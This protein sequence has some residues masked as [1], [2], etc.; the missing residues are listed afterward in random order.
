MVN[1]CRIN[2]RCQKPSTKWLGF[3]F[4][5]HLHKHHY[6]FGCYETKSMSDIFMYLKSSL[7]NKHWIMSV[8]TYRTPLIDVHISIHSKFCVLGA[9]IG[10]QDETDDRSSECTRVLSRYDPI[11]IHISI[12]FFKFPAHKQYSGNTQED[13]D[14]FFCRRPCSQFAKV[15]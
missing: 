14:E 12:W 10:L 2:H 7:A 11:L 13:A 1:R 5:H 3:F 6:L 4:N 9:V 15:R 8:F